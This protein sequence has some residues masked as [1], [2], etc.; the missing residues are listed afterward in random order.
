M[1][2]IAAVGAW[3]SLAGALAAVAFSRSDAARS[4]R[5]LFR[6]IAATNVASALAYALVYTRRGWQRAALGGTPGE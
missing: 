3:E 2:R 1:S 4:R 6:C 5:V